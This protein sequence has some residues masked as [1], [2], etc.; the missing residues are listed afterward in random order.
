MK[1]VNLSF[2][3]FFLVIALTITTT[4]AKISLFTYIWNTFLTIAPKINYLTSY[5]IICLIGLCVMNLI[6]MTAT[7]ETDTS[8]KV[9]NIVTLVV[10]FITWVCF[11]LLEWWFL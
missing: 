7:E 4:L 11:A 1:T 2:A 10:L 6:P 8:Y 3:E 9:K 5:A